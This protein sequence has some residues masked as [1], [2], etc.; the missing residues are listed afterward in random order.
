MDDQSTR[1][2][3]TE[4]IEPVEYG[5]GVQREQSLTEEQSNLATLFESD[6]NPWAS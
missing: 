5:E 3:D 2:Q 1:Y 6:E 4:I